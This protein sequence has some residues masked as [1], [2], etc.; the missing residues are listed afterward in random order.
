MYYSGIIQTI[1]FFPICDKVVMVNEVSEEIS[2]EVL[3]FNAGH[4]VN[5][6][7][8]GVQALTSVR[9]V[10]AIGMFNDTTATIATRITD[11]K[12]TS[13]ICKKGNIG[14]RT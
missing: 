2:I 5:F 8:M 3:T 14:L 4:S 9:Y 7:W 13:R 6:N 12:T 10:V 1:H 11:M